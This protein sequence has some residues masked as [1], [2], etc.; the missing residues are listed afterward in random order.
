MDFFASLSKSITHDL[1]T[2]PQNIYTS[3]RGLHKSYNLTTLFLCL[4]FL[5][6][7]A[8]KKSHQQQKRSNPAAPKQPQH[9]KIPK[10][11]SNN[12]SATDFK[13]IIPT[14]TPQVHLFRR[15][16]WIAILAYNLTTALI[17]ALITRKAIATVPRT[18][19]KV[20]KTYNTTHTLNFTLRHVHTVRTTLPVSPTDV[21][22]PIWWNVTGYVF[23]WQLV[24]FVVQMVRSESELN[25]DEDEVAEKRTTVEMMRRASRE[26]KQ[27]SQHRSK[28]SEERC[29]IL[30]SLAN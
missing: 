13:T 15:K 19:E 24:L 26:A 1:L 6:S 23:F 28:T 8:Y 7:Q 21:P 20:L 18:D 29:S 30:K 11:N 2:L 16:V 17:L 4:L 10:E 27:M 5:W 14:I 25:E 22:P 9:A 12:T 3:C